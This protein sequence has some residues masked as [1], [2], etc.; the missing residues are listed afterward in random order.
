M[1]RR[2]L[3]RNGVPLDAHIDVDGAEFV[4]HSRGGKR[5]GANAR[6]LD[7]GTALR[8]LLE[9]ISA[10]GHTIEGAWVDSDEVRHLDRNQRSILNGGDLLSGPQQQFKVLSARMQAFGRA[11]DAPYGGSRVKKIRLRIG[12]IET[13]DGLTDV[14]ELEETNGADGDARALSAIEADHLWEAIAL[15]GTENS[16]G[17]AGEGQ[18]DLVVEERRV[19]P[20]AVV[21]IAARL[22]TGRPLLGGHS[23]GDLSTAYARDLLEREGFEVVPAGGSPARPD[24]PISN[25]DREWSEGRPILVAH[26]KRERAP[27]LAR[28]KKRN[29]LRRL[30]RLACERCGLDPFEAFGSE[31]GLACLEVHHS[32]LEIAQMGGGARTT[33]ADVQLLCANCHRLVHALMREQNAANR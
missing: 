15:V 30:G 10:K 20:E 29:V 33:L 25:E 6:N 12:G 19:R 18:F 23:I 5:G 9:R 22:A 4:F 24:I 26:L 8:L 7:Y 16:A 1:A 21:A 17:A 27:G 28:A 32:R 31:A 11:P 2:V 3:D 13:V 14:L